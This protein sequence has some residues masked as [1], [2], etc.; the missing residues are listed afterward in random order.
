[1]KSIKLKL[2][3]SGVRA[4]LGAALAVAAVTVPAAAA[5]A[6]AAAQDAAEAVAARPPT[7]DQL[8]DY[9][10]AVQLDDVRTVL[11]LIDQRVVNPNQADP[12]SGETA[13]ILALR[14]GVPRVAAALIGLPGIDL[15]AHAPNGNTALMMAAYK[16]KLAAVQALLAAGAR[17]DQP[18]WNALHNAAAS[19]ADDAAA[20]AGLLLAHGAAI[21]ARGPAGTTALMMAAREGREAMVA[22]LL[23]AGADAALRNS[24]GLNAVQLAERA[25]HKRIVRIIADHAKG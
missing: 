23:E 13:L 15:E 18:G 24:E 1:M 3:R 16:G 10:R 20:I 6:P 7:V 9:F 22:L 19:G 2:A 8:T 21:D 11:R 14:E 4:V 17:I 5:A 12:R 25:E